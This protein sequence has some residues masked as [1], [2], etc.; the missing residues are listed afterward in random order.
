MSALPGRREVDVVA[1]TNTQAGYSLSADRTHPGNAPRESIRFRR[2]CNAAKTGNS[3]RYRGSNAESRR[4][5]NRNATA[6]DRRADIRVVGEQ[7]GA[8]EVGVVEQRREVRGRGDAEARLD[9]AAG[10]HE[11]A[12]RARRRDHLQRLAQSAA[13]GK[14]DVDAVHRADQ[15]GNVGRQPRKTRRRSPEGWTVRGRTAAR[16]CRAP[17]PAARRT[18]RRI[19]PARRPSAAPAWRVHAALASTRRILSGAASRTVRM[20]CSSRSVPS[21]ILSTGYELAC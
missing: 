20:M 3:C 14:L 8:V 4:R 11:H 19:P 10:H 1:T 16:R 5:R 15:P 7:R 12:V 13:L 21:L 18:P 6:V 17:A 2:S 9:H